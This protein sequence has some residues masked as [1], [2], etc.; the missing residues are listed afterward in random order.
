MNNIQP[1]QEFAARTADILLEI[2][3]VNFNLKDPFILTSGLPSPVYVDCRRIISYP[4]ARE[5]IVKMMAELIEA[6]VGFEAIANIAG[7]ES[8]GIPF[9]ALVASEMNLPMTYIRK[10]PKGHGRKTRIEGVIK[11]DQRV[12]LVEDLATD[13]GSKISFV[14][15]IRDAG[16]VCND[17]IVVFYYGVFSDAVPKLKSHSINL[18]FLTNWEAILNSNRIHTLLNSDEL[19]SVHQFLNNPKEWQKIYQKVSG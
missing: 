15:A 18:H 4:R 11:K 19:N 10:K 5:A 17:T 1:N 16:G 7:G 2:K 6:S 13:G 3:A 14:D 8:A 9:G 12:L